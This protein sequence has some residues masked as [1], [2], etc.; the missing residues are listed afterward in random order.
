MANGF[1]EK[2]DQEMNAQSSCKN[3]IGYKLSLTATNPKEEK[4]REIVNFIN[5]F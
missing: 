4:T 3:I 5:Y 2:F 1:N